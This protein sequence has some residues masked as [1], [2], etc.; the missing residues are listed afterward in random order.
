MSEVIRTHW[1]SHGTFKLVSTIQAGQRACLLYLDEKYLGPYLSVQTAI[2]A[3][4]HGDLNEDLGFD[5]KT[6]GVPE[7]YY[8]WN[9]L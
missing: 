5:G 4:L 9:N 2:A 7:F 1:T 8:K 3:I 6:S